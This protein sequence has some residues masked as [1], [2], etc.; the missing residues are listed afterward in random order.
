MKLIFICIL[1]VL[2]ACHGESRK[3]GTGE[4][5]MVHQ[6]GKGFTLFL[7]KTDTSFY[8]LQRK[9]S[10]LVPADCSF[11]SYDKDSLT[12]KDLKTSEIIRYKVDHNIYGIGFYKGNEFF[13]L[14]TSGKL[15]ELKYR[16]NL[17]DLI[18]LMSCLCHPIAEVHTCAQGGVGID[19]C[20]YRMAR[21]EKDGAWIHNCQVSCAQGYNACCN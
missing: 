17:P 10:I 5:N 21:L 7:N 16:D 13:E 2:V 18:P 20:N 15:G 4:G 6:S 9:D 3:P 19:F 12:I 1:S 8:L 11:N 14:L